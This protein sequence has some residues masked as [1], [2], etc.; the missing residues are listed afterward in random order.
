MKKIITILIIM[1]IVLIAS[2]IAYSY[3]HERTHVQICK[4]F[5]ADNITFEFGYN[6][7]TTCDAHSSQEYLLAQSNVEAF[8]YQLCAFMN[9]FI[10]TLFAILIVKVGEEK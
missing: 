7:Y 9:I 6:G 5:G 2:N 1:I 3:T 8:G 10:F 4:Y